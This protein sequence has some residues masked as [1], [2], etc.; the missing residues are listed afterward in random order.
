MTLNVIPDFF[1][2]IWL[3]QKIINISFKHGSGGGSSIPSGVVA[4]KVVVA[5]MLV[6]QWWQW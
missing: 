5:V 4:E 6:W 3:A 1:N 2:V